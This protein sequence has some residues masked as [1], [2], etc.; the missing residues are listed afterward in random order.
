VGYLYNACLVF[1]WRITGL[2]GV[3]M[4]STDARTLLD[5]KVL[6]YYRSMLYI[7]LPFYDF[8]VKID[9]S[10]VPNS[11]FFFRSYALFRPSLR[12]FFQILFNNHFTLP[13]TYYSPHQP[14]FLLDRPSLV[15]TPSLPPQRSRPPP[16]T[17]GAVSRAR[18]SRPTASWSVGLG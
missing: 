12:D 4:M 3:C 18:T 10:F 16:A 8:L 13:I 15:P 17:A 1:M 7:T 2:A 14:K 9:F 6:F 5:F 11:F